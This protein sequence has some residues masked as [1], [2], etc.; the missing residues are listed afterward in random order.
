MH[1][2]TD[3]P[4]KDYGMT[5]ELNERWV[6]S[7]VEFLEKG[8][9]AQAA[10]IAAGAVPDEQTALRILRAVPIEMLKAEIARRKKRK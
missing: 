3:G 5:D 9:A 4:G 8:K 7:M 1:R 2:A 6:S 10:A